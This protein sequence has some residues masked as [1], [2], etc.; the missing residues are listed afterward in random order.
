M[1]ENINDWMLK[2]IREENN[3]G[4]M[5]GWLEEDRYKWTR[6][7]ANTLNQIL[8]E[9]SFILVT[10]QAREWLRQYILHNINHSQK[11]R[12][13]VPIIGMD[14]FPSSH[15][16]QAEENI[17]MFKDMLDI[18]YKSYTFFYIGKRDNPIAE[19]AISQDNS[20]LWLL[21]ENLEMAFSLS[22]QSA[23]L[24]FR[25]LQLYKIFD[26]SLSALILGKIS[27]ED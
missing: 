15:T 2:T 20:F 5:S 1:A 8:K 19:L 17:A 18:A 26:H 16:I 14:C 7:V 13:F 10:D 23:M 6:I 12:P 11:N 9:T 3:N 21:D 4:L 27:L 25:L 22:S 24:D